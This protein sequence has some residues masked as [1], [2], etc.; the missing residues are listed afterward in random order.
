MG[1]IQTKLRL[2]LTLV[3]NQLA[4]THF[5]DEIPPPPLIHTK[6]HF[7]TQKNLLSAHSV[8]R[9]TTENCTEPLY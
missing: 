9:I 2:T 3:R 4:L 5:L 7:Y 1:G 6:T 8:S